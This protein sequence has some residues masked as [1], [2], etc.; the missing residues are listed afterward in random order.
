MRL[1]LSPPSM[2]AGSWTTEMRGSDASARR[3]CR[4]WDPERSVAWACLPNGR[5]GGLAPITA[6]WRWVC[7]AGVRALR[8]VV[9]LRTF[10][11]K[12]QHRRRVDGGWCADGCGRHGVGSF[13]GGGWLPR[14]P[15]WDCGGVGRYVYVRARRYRVQ[16]RALGSMAG[17]SD[18]AGQ[19]AWVRVATS[20]AIAA[21]R[22]TPD[23]DRGVVAKQ[24]ASVRG[25]QGGR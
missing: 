22:G 5:P 8:T 21:C 13:F 24:R 10:L 12:Q 23:G 6:R 14:L 4:A 19:Q 15:R 18:W 9:H 25:R 11:G 7:R 17:S 16:I 2:S 3:Q 1:S 20:F